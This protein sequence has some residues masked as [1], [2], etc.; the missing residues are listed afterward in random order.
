MWILAGEI[1]RSAWLG[2]DFANLN[3]VYPRETFAALGVSRRMS[4][5]G[6][7]R[8]I[9]VDNEMREVSGHE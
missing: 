7:F 8:A 6:R 9:E 1:S 2:I 3:A 5:G 4:A